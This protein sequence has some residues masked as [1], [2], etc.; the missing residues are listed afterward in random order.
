MEGG[1]VHAD[2]T[3]QLWVSLR[4]EI[5]SSGS[6]F[7]ELDGQSGGLLLRISPEGKLLQHLPA[8]VA[9]SAL[10]HDGT[11]LWTLE[12]K[13]GAASM[14]LRQRHPVSGVSMEH[15]VQVD[16][17]TSARFVLVPL[18][19][20]ELIVGRLAPSG[21]HVISRWAVGKTTLALRWLERLPLP[22]SASWFASMSWNESEKAIVVLDYFYDRST[23]SLRWQVAP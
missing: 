10:S 16:P 20:N 19:N 2:P 14:W 8:E 7:P 13:K 21:G 18:A 9:A 11:T 5:A 4:A 15:E 23:Q 3:G 1:I 6:A 22:S 12:G 17:Q